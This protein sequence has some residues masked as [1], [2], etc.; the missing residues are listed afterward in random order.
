MFEKI[1]YWLMDSGDPGLTGTCEINLG[2]G[3]CSF[4]GIVFLISGASELRKSGGTA[5]PI[6]FPKPFKR[7]NFPELD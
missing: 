5:P 4:I 3:G 6:N 1:D 7:W 2:G